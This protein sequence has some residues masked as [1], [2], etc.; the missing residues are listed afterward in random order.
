VCIF[1]CAGA[2]Q[3]QRPWVPGAGVTG[4]SEPLDVGAEN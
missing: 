4:S 1:E 3:S 2:H